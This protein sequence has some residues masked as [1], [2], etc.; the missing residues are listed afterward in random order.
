M[1]STDLGPTA[2]WPAPAPVRA[3]F[4]LCAVCSRRT[5]VVREISPSCC[6]QGQ[7]Y[8]RV[9][10]LPQFR[11]G[12]LSLECDSRVHALSVDH[13]RVSVHANARLSD[14]NPDR[15]HSGIASDHTHTHT[16]DG[17]GLTPGDPQVRVKNR[18]TLEARCGSTTFTAKAVR[19]FNP[20][21]RPSSAYSVLST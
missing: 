4:A 2:P 10:E 18:P 11:F 3:N 19:R 13:A 6:W 1:R 9:G 8:D 5:P 17:G 7:H 16:P 12:A 15:A 20:R 14:G 21:S